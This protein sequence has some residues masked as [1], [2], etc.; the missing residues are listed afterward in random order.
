MASGSS[1]SSMMFVRTDGTSHSKEVMT[2]SQQE[3]NLALSASLVPSQP[4][5]SCKFFLLSLIYQIYR[6]PNTDDVVVVVVSPTT[7]LDANRCVCE[8]CFKGYPRKQNLLLHQRVHNL[9]FTLK[10]TQNDPVPRKV[11]LCPEPTCAHHNRSHAIMDFGGLRKHYLRKH[12]TEKN[13]KCNTCPKAYSVQ[14]DLT[15]H[16]KICSSGGTRFSR[17]KYF[18]TLD[19]LGDNS[20]KTNR[21][22]K[23]STLLDPNSNA[24][25][26]P[27][28]SQLRQFGPDPIDLMT[29]PSL[30][31]NFNYENPPTF[32]SPSSIHQ[33]YDIGMNL[34]GDCGNANYGTGEGS[35][36]ILDG[37]VMLNPSTSLNFT[38]ARYNLSLNLM[39][40]PVTGSSSDGGSHEQVGYKGYGHFD[41]SGGV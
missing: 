8:V 31:L 12:C 39:H 24:Y 32:F 25:T 5:S 22:E 26:S 11:Y 40:N 2:Q 14:S 17:G 34:M 27:Y 29:E 10:R 13:Y 41:Y 28:Q 21:N 19:L 30:G 23:I 15:A 3:S 18:H 36:S 33:S 20:I 9:H 7:L 6:N 38:P 35:N 37:G 1:S 4:E 16:S